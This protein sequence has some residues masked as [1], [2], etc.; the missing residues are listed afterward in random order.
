VSVSREKIDL[1]THQA[2]VVGMQYS[3]LL[4]ATLSIGQ[5]QPLGPGDHKRS[6]TVDDLKRHHYIHVPAKYDPKEPAA[7]VLALH[8]AIMDA[9]LMEVFTGLSETA[10]KHNFIVVYP[11]GTGPGG[12]FQTWNAG[13]RN[14]NN[15]ADD[16]K[17]LGK[18][19]DDV[20]GVLQVNKKRVYVIGLSNGGM[21]TYRLASEMSARIAA[22]AS[23]AGTMPVE[24]Y[25]PARPVSVI[26]FH[27]TKDELVPYKGPGEKKEVADF[28]RVRSVDDTVMACVMA[29][30]CYAKPTETEIAMKKDKIKVI[31]K[32]FGK[33]K[34]DSEVVLY[35]VEN[36]GH[37][38]PGMTLSPAFLGLST[39]NISA[40][41][42]MWDFFKKHA[43][44]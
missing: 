34:D 22:I 11:N 10:D 16:V 31:R 13:L 29:N 26:H 4:I 5:A 38:W 40:N 35:V 44:K 3:L 33:G 2:K 15:K 42:L 6:I 24:K 23:V 30:A 14:K 19:L 43:R 9:K 37:T 27:G 7:V 41:E 12:F 21:M 18:V 20:E 32:E 25:Q 36:G 17:Y 39:N 1:T 28:M 8:G